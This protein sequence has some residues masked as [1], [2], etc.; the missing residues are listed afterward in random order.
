[1][2]YSVYFESNETDDGELMIGVYLG[3]LASLVS[4]LAF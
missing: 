2:I 3:T 4:Q 1:V